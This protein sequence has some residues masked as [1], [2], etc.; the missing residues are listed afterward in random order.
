MISQVILSSK[1]LPTN[2]ARIRPLIGMR[3]LVDQQIVALRELPVAE[4]A[5]ELF[6]RSRRTA[7]HLLGLWSPPW[8]PQVLKLSSGV[9]DGSTSQPLRHEGRVVVH[10]IGEPRMGRVRTVR[11][12][13]RRVWLTVPRL[14]GVPGD[15]GGRRVCRGMWGCQHGRGAVSFL[16]DFPRMD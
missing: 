5:D 11:N 15:R 2:I 14:Q 3:P 6:L 8:T 16:L 4:L 13:L 1:G 7:D 9:A 10:G 12:R